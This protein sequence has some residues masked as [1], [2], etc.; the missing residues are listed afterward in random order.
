[1]S[2]GERRGGLPCSEAGCGV[3]AYETRA[4]LKDRDTRI[5]LRGIRKKPARRAEFGFQPRRNPHEVVM[6]EIPFKCWG[7][8]HVFV[9]LTCCKR[10]LHWRTNSREPNC[11]SQRLGPSDRLCP[12]R[13]HRSRS[14]TRRFVFMP[15]FGIAG[16]RSNVS[17]YEYMPYICRMTRARLDFL[18]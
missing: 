2:A 17:S 18:I 15:W 12:L 13:T 7:E 1:M 5:A 4:V 3:S 16:A 11:L 6:G 10:S 9:S 14:D 8:W